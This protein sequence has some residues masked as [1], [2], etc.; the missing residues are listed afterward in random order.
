MAVIQ[1]YEGRVGFNDETPAKG[2]RQKNG[3][4]NKEDNVAA[5]QDEIT[6]S[7]AMQLVQQQNL[8]QQIIKQILQNRPPSSANKNSN[9]NNTK[10][11]LVPCT[12]CNV[13]LQYHDDASLIQCPRCKSTMQIENSAITAMDVEKD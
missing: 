7:L 6:T 3:R 11:K 1:F 10:T 9:Q 5:E 13:L 12:G 2:R 8:Q 4:N